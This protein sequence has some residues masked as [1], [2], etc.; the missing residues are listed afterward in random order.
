LDI[1]HLLPFRT[2]R[3]VEFCD[4]DAAGIVHFA[5][6][7][8]YM[9]TAEHEMLRSVGLSVMQPAG[10]HHV[11]WPRVSV[12]CDFRKP[13]RFDDVLTIEVGIEQL[14]E[15]S[16][17]YAFRFLRDDQLLATGKTTAVCCRI[18][19]GQPP[20]SIVIPEEMRQKLAEIMTNDQ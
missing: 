18:V 11:S 12:A 8:I 6:F 2:T 19:H 16:V 20:L 3:R 10:D 1:V 15:K 5:R 7:F 13:A 9:E 14:G 17:T 4:T